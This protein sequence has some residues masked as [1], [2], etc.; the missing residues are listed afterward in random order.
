MSKDISTEYT[1]NKNMKCG[2]KG[3]CGFKK[4]KITDIPPREYGM[5]LQRKRK[6]GVNHG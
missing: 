1:K 3:Y 6:G 5:F 2:R 4:E